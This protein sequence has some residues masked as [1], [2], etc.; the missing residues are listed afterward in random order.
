MVGTPSTAEPRSVEALEL[1]ALLHPTER[2]RLTLA[3][4][5]A[6]VVAAIFVVIMIAIHRAPQLAAVA[7]GL[8][9]LLASIWLG[10]QVRRAML[11]GRSVR[12]TERSLPVV[13]NVLDEVRARL[14]Y[15]GRIDVYVV[16]KAPGGLPVTVVSY[17]GTKLIVI[18]GGLI[19]DL[20]A[21]EK[22]PQLT[23]LLARY[24]GAFKARHLRMDIL[25]ALLSAVNGLR[26]A[27]LF[28]K[29]YFRATAYSGDQ[30]GLACCG[31]LN[32]AL[33]ATSRL[34]TGKDVAPSVVAR[35]V[36]DQAALVSRRLVPRVGQLVSREPHL[37]NRFLNL[38][39]FAHV[40]APAAWNA[41]LREVD[42]PTARELAI[43]GAR[44][45][46]TEGLIAAPPAVA[47]ERRW[48]D[49]LG[50]IVSAAGAMVAGAL[51][52]VSEIVAD[53]GLREA[54]R[55]SLIVDAAL[56]L[57]LLVAG[58]VTLLRR[59]P[60]WAAVTALVAVMLAGWTGLVHAIDVGVAAASFDVAM[61]ELARPLSVACAQVAAIL[62]L[63]AALA[64]TASWRQQPVT[65]DRRPTRRSR[66][67]AVGAVAGGALVVG[68]TFLAWYEL[69]GGS[70]FSAET[71]TLWQSEAGVADG[72]V[73]VS[74]AALVCVGLAGLVTRSRGLVWVTA[75]L[76]C[77]TFGLVLSPQD[78][79]EDY[80]V[81]TGW[82]LGLAGAVLALG[83]SLLSWVATGSRST[84]G[85]RARGREP[86]R[87]G[88]APAA[89]GI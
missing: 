6:L 25:E 35:G 29:P 89:A 9:V 32:T 8:L 88:A 22:R 80:S 54:D 20:L 23:F 1:R 65:T 62:A 45:P 86:H 37:T 18:E 74:A 39:F 60:V 33:A 83:C 28:L 36:I 76:A 10:L 3:T 67:V 66:L 17:F 82:W 52:A 42:E 69:P 13:Q 43:L 64:L 55:G 56:V 61:S 72:V 77:I 79:G 85:A 78:L 27:N 81:R 19:G 12:V 84:G 15:H 87:P 44:S 70:G 11:L 47:G 40:H 34:M 5:A 53:G 49:D 63:L 2:S 14:D 48:Q 57:A 46:H 7:A 24:V 30:I 21:P 16:D 73:A 71:L 75:L 38:L 26:V 41:F 59:G 4:V 58:S 68:S 50:T 31:D 51:L